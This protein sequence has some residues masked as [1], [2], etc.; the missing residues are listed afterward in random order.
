MTLYR[1]LL[2]TILLLF[3]V[4]F[5]TAYLALFKSTRDYLAEQQYTNVVNT[6]TSLGLALTPYLET[7][8]KVGAESVI[9][10]VFDGGFYR[11][12]RL[13]LLAA[14]DRILRENLNYPLRVPAWFVGLDLF[15]SVSYETVLTSGWLQLGK[16]YIEGH[17]NQAYYELW[18]GM[19]RLASWF[20]FF[21]VIA[22]ISLIVALRYLL[23]PLFM[24]RHQAKEIELHHFGK[25]I[26]LP[27]TRELRD[28]VSAI[29]NMSEKLEF[30]FDEQAREVERLRQKAFFDETSGLGN[31]SYFVS[32]ASS[33]LADGT[34]GAV[35]LVSAVLLDKV[36]QDEGF[37]ARDHMVRTIADNLRKVC[38]RYHEFALSRISAN[39]YALLIPEND[40]DKLTMLGHEI[41]RVIAELV[42]NPVEGDD[43]SV[44]GISVFHKGASV[45]NLLASAD[46]ALNKARMEDL[47]AVV[48]EQQGPSARL[49]RLA[50]KK[51]IAEAIHH[52]QL[53]FSS[54]NVQT[55]NGSSY[56]REL[57][58]AIKK[59]DVLFNASEFM[60]VVERFNMGAEFDGYIIDKAL[61]KLEA[62]TSL[63]LAVNLTQQSC[64]NDTFWNQLSLTLTQHRL[65]AERLFLEIPESVFAHGKVP[66]EQY[67]GS[68][69]VKWGI[70]H[71]GRHFDILGHLARL[72]PAYVK[73]DHAY[74][75]QILDAD[76]DD[77]FLAAV[78]RVAHNIGAT[79]IATRVENMEQRD[80]LSRLHI[81]AYQG[82]VSPIES[83]D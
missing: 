57:F 5:I 26:P 28:V 61:D 71:F 9:N 27:A 30:Q 7:S 79:V 36:Y 50:W 58:T 78:C 16:L 24:I 38:S 17:P 20:L 11:T 56:H 23:K 74:T 12:V 81:D 10:A 3:A 75:N 4:L 62:D 47:G 35:I 41:N 19:S 60:S 66:M 44:V 55:F 53:L 54:Q 31:R 6:A 45:S 29:N 80:S 25:K 2:I 14:D 77:A 40:T 52:E 46:N 18:K 83:L 51:L 8:D 37:A 1:Q 48:V 13:D 70:D 42:V 22:W 15:K 65:A 76:Y 39:E 82:F 43:F 34:Q 73:V 33:W 68:L 67:L 72:R 63:K 49:G 21:F 32:Q 64:H 69:N 59:D